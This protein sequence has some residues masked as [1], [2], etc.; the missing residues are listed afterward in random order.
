MYYWKNRKKI[1][2][3]IY[4]T[5]ILDDVPIKTGLVKNS[6]LII[7][8]K[9]KSMRTFS[10]IKSHLRKI[11]LWKNTMIKILFLGMR[12]HP[13]DQ[14]RRFQHPKVQHQRIQTSE[15]KNSITNQLIKKTVSYGD[16][17]TEVIKEINFSYTAKWGK[18]LH[19]E[20]FLNFLNDFMYE[21]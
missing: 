10:L 9:V 19:S 3:K 14:H 21:S 17:R 11:Y 6:T 18:F 13:K 15:K 4:L 1:S 8:S 5:E 12:K 2:S 7:P 20:V 16:G